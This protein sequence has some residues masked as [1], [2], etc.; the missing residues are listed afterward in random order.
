LE[1]RTSR[2]QGALPSWLSG[3]SLT[4]KATLNAV[5]AMLDYTA[6][7]LV[8]FA[9]NPLLVSGLGSYGFGL[10]QVLRQLIGYMSPASGRSSQAL[11]WSIARSQSSRDE[12]DKR[13]Q[14]GSAV[15]VWL[16]FAPVLGAVG[17]PLVWFGPIWLDVPLEWLPAARGAAALVAVN[18]ILTSLVELPRSVLTGENLGYKRMGLSAALVIAGGGLTALALHL[19]LGLVGVAA[20]PLVVSLLT[21]LLFLQV[22][23][24]HVSWF[25]VARP[26]RDAV[27]SFLGLSGWFLGWNVVMRVMRAS[28]VVVL[29]AFGGVA[30][31]TAYAITKYVP[32]ALLNLVA[33]LVQ[34]AAPG[35]GGI[36]GAGDLEKARRLRAEVMSITWL[37]CTAVG[38]TILLWNEAFVALWVGPEQFAGWTPTLCILLMMVQFAVLRNDAFI[39]DLTLDLRQK[40]LIG[41]LS[42]ALSV[43]AASALVGPGGLG[44]VGLCLGFVAGR[45][46][47]SIAYPWL[48]GRSLGIRALEQL[49]GAARPA[50]VAIALA[51]AAAR[52]SGEVGAPGWTQLVFGV[53]ATAALAT[54]IAF[55]AGLPARLRRQLLKRVRR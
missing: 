28:D 38:F 51:A 11:K 50:L 52:L 4:G 9:I 44:V 40:V 46:I 37:V 42:A 8:G 19:E 13:R 36:I 7:L 16:L 32:E 6:R 25:G 47:L 48:I 34:E 53:A 30:G 1:D 33:I 14:V 55:F 26:A 22:V 43:A 3:R 54:G 49:R 21:G 5:T 10:W 41:A 45:S 12:L 24:R 2:L 29:G 27:R 20:C 35:L 18:V 23:R 17:A 15:A 39:I 31:V